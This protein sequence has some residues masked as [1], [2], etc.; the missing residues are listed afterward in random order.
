VTASVRGIV[1]LSLALIWGGAIAAASTPPMG[2][3]SYDAYG[4]TIDEAQ[5]RANARWMSGQ[6]RQFGWHYIVVDMA[7][8]VRNPTLP[9]TL[10]TQSSPST[11]MAAT[12]RRRTDFRRRRRCR[13][14]AALPRKQ[15]LQRQ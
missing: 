2:W 3:N 7:W 12:F 14:R 5:L 1:A 11:P 8:Y 4:T 15:T 13:L 10:P 9:A 6:L